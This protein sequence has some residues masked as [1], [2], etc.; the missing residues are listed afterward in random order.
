M[1]IQL[2]LNLNQFIIAQ[3]AIVTVVI[4]LG[5]FAYVSPYITG[6]DFLFG[7]LRLLDVGREQSIPT[8]I[9]AINLLLASILACIIY[10]FEKANSLP[11]SVYWLILSILFLFLSIDESAGIH[12]NFENVHDYLVHKELIFPI[13]YTHNWLPFGVLF[14]F[15]IVIV[16]LPFLSNLSTD[17]LRNFLIAGGVFVTGAIGLEFLGAVMLETGMAESTMDMTYLVRRL[18]EEGFEMYG[19]A[20]FNCALYHEVLRRKICLIIGECQR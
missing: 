8:Y 10:N 17:T 11:R 4:A 12:E 19:V 6:H 14:V 7:F 2:S 13:L 9:S 3:F 15:A 18:F 1:K 20:I 5:L 16:L